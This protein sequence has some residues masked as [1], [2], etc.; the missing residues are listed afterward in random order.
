MNNLDNIECDDEYK[1]YQH[2][3]RFKYY[4]LGNN[5]LNISK[6]ENVND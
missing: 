1:S 5:P 4:K 3:N 2:I 6:I